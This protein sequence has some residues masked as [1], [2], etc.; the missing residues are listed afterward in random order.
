MGAL[1]HCWE[2]LRAESISFVTLVTGAFPPAKVG[3]R[4][5]ERFFGDL[6]QFWRFNRSFGDLIRFWAIDAIFGNL[7][8]IYSIR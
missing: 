6:F 3:E 8:D 5:R 1:K 2:I 4:E 7:R